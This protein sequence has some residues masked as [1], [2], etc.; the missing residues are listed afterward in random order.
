[1]FLLHFSGK[2]A[3]RFYQLVQEQH[4]D[5][6]VFSDATLTRFDLAYSRFLEP[7]DNI[8]VSDFLIKTQKRVLEIPRKVLFES[9][10]KGLILRIGNRKTVNYVRIYKKKHNNYLRFEH[11]FKSKKLKHFYVLLKSRQFDRFEDL[12]I[13]KVYK[14]LCKILPLQYCYTDW[15][16]ATLRPVATTAFK[17]I[18]NKKGINTDYIKSKIVGDPIDLVRFIKFLKFTRNLDYQTETLD[19]GKVIFRVF[20]FEIRSFLATEVEKQNRY[21]IAKLKAFFK[22][23]HKNIVIESFENTYFQSLA[24]VPLARV[25]KPTRPGQALIAQVWVADELFYYEFPFYLPDL[26]FL[27]LNKHEINVRIH[28]IQ[29]FC[30]Y[31]LQKIFYISKFIDIYPSAISGKQKTLIKQYFIDA[32]QFLQ[33]CNLIENQYQI[34]SDGIFKSVSKLTT[35]NIS[36]GFVIFE[37]IHYHEIRT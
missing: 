8:T 12:L 13:R 21:Q 27:K 25:Y 24:A 6:T 11:E 37:K 14:Y 3:A 36:E 17:L 35:R 1:L 19:N 5:W 9:N 4:I 15:L 33:T 2:N 7:S 28:V 30:I 32:V 26:F 29:S 20:T 18:A 10:N 16:I 22:G 34:I 31:K 23:L